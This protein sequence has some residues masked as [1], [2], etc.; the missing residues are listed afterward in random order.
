MDAPSQPSA[1]PIA[2]GAADD[3]ALAALLRPQPPHPRQP[4]TRQPPRSRTD[5]DALTS[6]LADKSAPSAPPKAPKETAPRHLI[7]ASDGRT[8]EPADGRRERADDAALAGLFGKGHSSQRTPE[9][10]AAE[11]D[12]AALQDLLDGTAIDKRETATREGAVAEAPAGRGVAAE[13]ADVEGRAEILEAIPPLVIDRPA[14]TTSPNLF[15]TAHE[16]RTNWVRYICKK[17][18]E[19]DLRG[20]DKATY[21]AKQL[22]EEDGSALRLPLHH[23]AFS[24]DAAACDALLSVGSP[25]SPPDRH[26]R[27]P[28]HYAGYRGDTPCIRVILGH[29]WLRAVKLA[30]RKI[31]THNKLVKGASDLFDPQAVRQVISTFYSDVSDGYDTLILFPDCRH[32]LPIHFAIK[33][34]YPGCNTALA[35]MLTTLLHPP[36]AYG[37]AGEAGPSD[38][39][40]GGSGCPLLRGVKDT[41]DMERLVGRESLLFARKAEGK[42]LKLAA[43]MSHQELTDL[44]QHYQLRALEVLRVTVRN[45]HLL[46]HAQLCHNPIAA[47]IL[48]TLTASPFSRYVLSDSSMGKMMRIAE[49]VEGSATAAKMERLGS[50]AV[51]TLVLQGN[52]QALDEYLLDY[53][54]TDVLQTDKSGWTGLH[55]AASMGRVQELER[56]LYHLHDRRS[57]EVD[58]KYTQ[59]TQGSRPPVQT[60]SALRLPARTMRGRTPLHLAA[61]CNQLGSQDCLLSAPLRCR[62]YADLQEVDADLK[63]PLL[64]AAEAG[65]CEA[66]KWFLSRHADDPSRRPVP[67][68]T[69]P[70]QPMRQ[71]GDKERTHTD[72]YAMDRHRHCGLH[73]AVIGQHLHAAALF[74]HFDAD[75]TLLQSHSDSRGNTF[76]IYLAIA[77]SSGRPPPTVAI[78]DDVGAIWEGRLIVWD[79]AREGDTRRLANL[80]ESDNAELSRLSPAGWLAA[81]YAAQNGRVL[82]LRHLIKRKAPI[83]FQPLTRPRNGDTDE[84]EGQPEKCDDHVGIPRVGECLGQRMPL[85]RSIFT[86]P[87]ALPLRGRQ[88][89]HLAAEG[90]HA[91]VIRTLHLQGG[92]DVNSRAFSPTQPGNAIPTTDTDD[93]GWTP[94]MAACA[95]GRARAA[96]VLIELGADPLLQDEN[97]ST[98]AHIAAKKGDADFAAALGVMFDKLH[99]A[100]QRATGQRGDEQERHGG[101]HD[102]VDVAEKRGAEAERV[103]RKSTTFRMARVGVG[104]VLGTADNQGRTPLDV[105]PP[106]SPTSMLIWSW[107]E[108]RRPLEELKDKWILNK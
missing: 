71:P 83:Q 72:G 108:P 22:V 73:L 9:A 41:R 20:D 92:C 40:T 74:L 66:I 80:K 39:R 38:L 24:G 69:I 44:D 35:F 76:A 62:E 3:A 36:L 34:T 104:E 93:A 4:H 10:A 106:Y 51:R 68:A 19:A 107:Q 59:K 90:D 33:N 42:L 50:D 95:N 26:G 15:S 29:L 52:F 77:N 89:I 96:G 53:P 103:K 46:E 8:E 21:T 11:R 100:H 1:A 64:M 54:D 28:M 79:L 98:A 70:S 61:R 82:F 43:L 7:Q 97:G 67:P 45:S 31:H 81:H 49:S 57:L 85:I 48:Q 60:T 75:R 30:M 12:A 37:A 32:F 58:P 5:D 63:A 2:A 101:R 105:A 88:P 18:H 94:L 56:L 16:E 78:Y 102:D 6:L 99:K 27:A 17:I 87:H 65:C 91:E 23:A 84:K 55:L 47:Q 86:R 25:L 14:H 13:D